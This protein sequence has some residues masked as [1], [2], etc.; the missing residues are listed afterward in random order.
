MLG[1]LVRVLRVLLNSLEEIEMQVKPL[2]TVYQVETAGY[3]EFEKTPESSKSFAI[4]GAVG[5]QWLS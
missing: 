4:S 5:V 3:V 1:A 2:A